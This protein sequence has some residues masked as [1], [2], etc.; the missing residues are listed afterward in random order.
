[1]GSFGQKGGSVFT[2]KEANPSGTKFSAIESAGSY[3]DDEDDSHRRRNKRSFSSV[4]TS[5]KVTQFAAPKKSQLRVEGKK[6]EKM[7]ETKMEP[8]SFG[9]IFRIMIIILVIIAVVFVVGSQ[10]FGVK[11]SM[12]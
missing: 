9:K 8:W 11:E 10:L 12:D 7:R 4:D 2:V 6:N 5:K 3:E 1:M